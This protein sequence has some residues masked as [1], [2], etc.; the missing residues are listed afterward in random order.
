MDVLEAM[1]T[2]R[3]E[4]IEFTL[5]GQPD[6]TE[7]NRGIARGIT[8]VLRGLGKAEEIMKNANGK[9]QHGQGAT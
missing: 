9:K 2:Y 7:T 6:M 3:G 8:E 5:Y 1:N 4:A